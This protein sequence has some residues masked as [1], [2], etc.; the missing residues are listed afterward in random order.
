M[1]AMSKDWRVRE[2]MMLFDIFF[3]YKVYPVE[4]LV[5]TVIIFIGCKVCG[6]LLYSVN[7]ICWL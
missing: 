5:V 7:F 1:L 4:V 2:A 6:W 3:N